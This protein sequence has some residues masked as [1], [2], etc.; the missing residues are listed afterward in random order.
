MHKQR[1]I[2]TKANDPDITNFQLHMHYNF[3]TCCTNAHGQNKT[4]LED[5]V[6]NLLTATDELK[7]STQST[8]D[9]VWSTHSI[10][11]ERV[12]ALTEARSKALK[13][14]LEEFL[15]TLSGALKNTEQVL[16]RGDIVNFVKQWEA[17]VA[18]RV[19]SVRDAA[20]RWAGE[21]A[22]RDAAGRDAAAAASLW[23]RDAAGAAA[24]RARL[25]AA[26][27][28]P[29]SLR[30]G[31]AVLCCAVLGAGRDAAAA[32][33]LWRRDAA[34]AA[35]RR[36]RLRAA[37]IEEEKSKLE[38]RL[39][40]QLEDLEEERKENKDRLDARLQEERAVFEQ[41]MARLAAD[42][43]AREERLSK[44]IQEIEEERRL[45]EERMRCQLEWQD[46]Q[47]TESEEELMRAGELF[48][49]YNSEADEAKKCHDNFAKEL[50][51]GTS[52]VSIDLEV[53]TKN[54]SEVTEHIVSEISRML[55]EAQLL[56][57]E[58]TGTA[59]EAVQSVV[60]SL[61]SVNA[62]TLEL[63]SCQVTV[64]TAKHQVEEFVSDL[65][66]TVACMASVEERYLVN[67][68]KQY[69]PSGGTPGR[70][71]YEYPRQLAA[72]SPHERILRRFRESHAA[73][74]G[75]LDCV[76][77][78]SE[79]EDTETQ[80]PQPQPQW[81]C[82]SPEGDRAPAAS[83]V[84]FKSTSESDLYVRRKQQEQPGQREYR[85]FYFLQKTVQASSAYVFEETTSGMEQLIWL[86]PL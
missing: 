43:Q 53:F 76:V 32:A 11:Q 80:Q 14:F 24:R 30:C 68:Y 74:A 13:C 17:G 73:A 58:L 22:R 6:K 18:E 8:N 85:P 10:H 42:T 67:E 16:T 39:S 25:R 46:Q 61:E 56:A 34:G 37:Q 49:Q 71:Q 72:T 83:P 19:R 29:S 5:L 79:D 28:A 27:S 78:E 12:E 50:D 38:S 51:N 54:I 52:A 84:I 9:S 60:E 82:D 62:A 20:G 40:K 47:V 3:V 21:R 35:A 65:K 23:R 36:A 55:T 63:S 70:V 31:R 41:R 2:D 86:S 66:E 1:E 48:D 7:Q 57:E 44:K 81:R 69:S 64:E 15:Q 4:K 59:S 77:I 26:V 75:D 45:L 33:S